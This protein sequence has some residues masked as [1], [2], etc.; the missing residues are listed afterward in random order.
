MT[1]EQSAAVPRWVLAAYGQSA[2][3]LWL[4]TGF[5]AAAFIAASIGSTHDSDVAILVGDVLAIIAAVAI[6]RVI[7]LHIRLRRL[8]A[9]DGGPT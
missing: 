8:S 7:A 2:L 5:F 3:W 1:E 4:S 9:A 6:V